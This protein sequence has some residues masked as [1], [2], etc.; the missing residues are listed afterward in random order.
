MNI[1][2]MQ[3]DNMDQHWLGKEMCIPAKASHA[4]KLVS[5]RFLSSWILVYVL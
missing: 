5:R 3:E 1:W 2:Y 4:I